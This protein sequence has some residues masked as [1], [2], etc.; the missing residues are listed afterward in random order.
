MKKFSILGIVAILIIFGNIILNL[1]ENWRSFKEGY[2]SGRNAA[3]EM[4]EKGPH[5]IP[6]YAKPARLYVQ[7]LPRTQIDSLT[8]N[9]IDWKIPYKIT[10][11]ETY[12]KPS[13]WYLLPL[14]VGCLGAIAFLYGF[15]CLIRLLIS[16]S[17]REIFTQTNIWRLR[18]FTYILVTAQL[19]LAISEWAIGRAAMQQISLPGYEILNPSSYTTSPT[20]LIVIVLFTEIFAVGVKI[21]EEQDLTI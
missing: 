2:D 20:L 17:R 15:Y 6:H 13:A 3:L 11:I 18:W 12:V 7:P 1:D 9:R 4:N 19:G 16:I 10:E 21:K 5:I 8:N 14:V